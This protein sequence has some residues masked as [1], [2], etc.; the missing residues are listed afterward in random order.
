MKPSFK[1]PVS[2][3]RISI[4]CLFIDNIR[5]I[6]VHFQG[7]LPKAGILFL[8][9]LSSD[10]LECWAKGCLLF[11]TS[12]DP[13]VKLAKACVDKD[14]D[15]MLSIHVMFGAF[16]GKQVRE[17]GAWVQDDLQQLQSLRLCFA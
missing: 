6:T 16:T 4:A 12:I 2:P 9:E 15:K 13:P 7:A 5:T 3:L 1:E 10:V 11:S 14:F 8:K 17:L